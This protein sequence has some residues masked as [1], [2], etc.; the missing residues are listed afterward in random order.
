MRLLVLLALLPGATGCGTVVYDHRIEVAF[1]DLSGQPVPGPVEVSIFDHAM[2]RSNEWARRTAGPATP[3]TSYV[4]RLSATATRTALDSSRLPEELRAGLALP[5]FSTTGFFALHL[6]PRAG[7]TETVQL[8][9]ASYNPDVAL[10]V[11]VPSLPAQ[12]TAEALEKGWL[13]RLTVTLPGVPAR[14]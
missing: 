10:A 7:E 6:R 2:G 4:G 14:P 12:M 3:A 9:F 1:R 8:P 11:P 13:I 5:G